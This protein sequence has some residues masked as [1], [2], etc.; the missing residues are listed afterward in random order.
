MASLDSLIQAPEVSHHT[1]G[2]FEIIANKY[3]LGHQDVG[4][5]DLQNERE[6]NE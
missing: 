1:F 5:G 4:K 6:W 2:P 3:P